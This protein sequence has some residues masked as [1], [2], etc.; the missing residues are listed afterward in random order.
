MSNKIIRNLRLSQRTLVIEW[1]EIDP[2][3][4][5]N[6]LESVYRHFATCFNI[7]RTQHQPADPGFEI[8][9]RNEWK[10]HFLGLPLSDRDRFF[11]FHTHDYYVVYFWQQNRSMY[12]GQE[13]ESLAV[14]DI[15]TASKYLPSADASGKHAPENQLVGGPHA[16]RRYNFIDLH[17]YGILQGDSPSM[18]SFQIDD[19]AENLYWVENEYIRPT[20]AFN[21]GQNQ[22]RSRVIIIPLASGPVNRKIGERS[23][24]PYAGSC[25]FE[26]R[27]QRYPPED[28]FIGV[29]DVYDAESQ[30]N[31][32]LQRT[33]FSG[34]F[35]W[36]VVKI[37]AGEETTVDLTEKLA[38]QVTYKGRIAGDERLLIGENSRQEIVI[39]IF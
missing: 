19:T 9:F 14:W 28:T 3:H 11:S 32:S 21:L 34:P 13:I 24:P 17:F 31:Y 27:D 22:W 18:M 6:E 36:T 35:N 1:A 16:L 7:I 26:A 12:T 8:T 25:S 30:V 29:M 10:I 5:L 4:Q 33:N 39:L 38:E 2:F 15:S 20:N 23:L 37:K